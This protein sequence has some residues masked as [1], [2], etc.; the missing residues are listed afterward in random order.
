MNLY[1]N[2]YI[3]FIYKLYKCSTALNIKCIIKLHNPHLQTHLFLF[4]TLSLSSPQTFFCPLFLPSLFTIY[5]P[6]LIAA[7][8]SPALF[9]TKCAQGLPVQGPASPPSSTPRGQHPFSRFYVFLIAVS[10]FQPLAPT[11]LSG[12]CRHPNLYAPLAVT[13]WSPLRGPGKASLQATYPLGLGQS[14]VAA[15][16]PPPSFEALI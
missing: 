9:K 12:D 16:A 8:S 6:P 3:S 13:M 15:T 10:C 2:L 5:T 11:R 1:P 4:Q 7:N 14:L